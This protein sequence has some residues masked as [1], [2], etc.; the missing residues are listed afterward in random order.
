[1]K[2]EVR[3]ICKSPL[4]RDIVAPLTYLEEYYMEVP[5]LA[6]PRGGILHYPS[7]SSNIFRAY[8]PS[9]LFSFARATNWRVSYTPKRMN[10]LCFLH[11][12]QSRVVP[13]CEPK[14]AVC[15]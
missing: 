11:L 3:F 1:M 7:L 2:H 6:V 5:G 14:P 9:E 8:P 10:G 12:A 4:R 15:I 13:Y